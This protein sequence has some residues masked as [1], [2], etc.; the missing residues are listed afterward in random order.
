MKPH[1]EPNLDYQHTAIEPVCDLLR[2]SASTDNV[3]KANLTAVLQ[4]N[5]LENIRSL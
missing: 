3:A 5:G 1:F 4:Q 2:D